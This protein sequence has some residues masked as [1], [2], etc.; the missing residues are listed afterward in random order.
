M[1]YPDIVRKVIINNFGKFCIYYNINN[2]N[3]LILS[4]YIYS[5]Y[6]LFIIKLFVPT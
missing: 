5:K 3:N 6:Y 4:L 1:A 2:F